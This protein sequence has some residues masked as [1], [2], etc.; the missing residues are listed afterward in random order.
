MSGANFLSPEL[1]L[2]PT[3]LDILARYRYAHAIA[4]KYSPIW[5]FTI[6]REFLEKSSLKSGYS[7]DEIGRAHV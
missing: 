1:L 6:Y 7:E 3:R 2:T 5:G 4:N